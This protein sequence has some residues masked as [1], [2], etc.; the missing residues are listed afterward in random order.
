MQRHLHCA[1]L[2]GDGDP[3]ERLVLDTPE[4]YEILKRRFAA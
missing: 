2:A 4:D 3:D 1:N